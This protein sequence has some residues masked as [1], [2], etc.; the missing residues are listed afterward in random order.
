MTEGM[1]AGQVLGA[2]GSRGAPRWQLGSAGAGR[3][4]ALQ[5]RWACGAQAGRRQRARQAQAGRKRGCARGARLGSQGA[6]GACL[7]AQAGRAG[8]SD[9]PSWC[10][11]HLAQF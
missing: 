6:R 8:W 5:A 4:D 11:V 9:R 10:I 2:Q 3:V 7:C 1:D